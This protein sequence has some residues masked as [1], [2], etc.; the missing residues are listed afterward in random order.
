MNIISGKYKNSPILSPNDIQT[1]PMGSREKLALF[2]S[3]VSHLDSRSLEGLR[4]LDAFAGTGALGLEALSRGA[5][6]VVFVEKS[7][8]IAKILE[9]NLENV[10]LDHDLIKNQKIIKKDVKNLEKTDFDGNFDLIFADPPYNFYSEALISPLVAFLA[11][12]AVLA[13]S[14]PKSAPTPVFEGLTP[15]S[16]KT[17]A[18]AKI[19]L[20]KKS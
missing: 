2:N 11:P 4:A 20:F 8:K 15:V 18:N 9:K 7:P 16:E 14:L 6:S 17:Y 5:S 3:L 1:H 19:I 12:R 10:L 13:L